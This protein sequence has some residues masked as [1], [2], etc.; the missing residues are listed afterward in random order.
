[1]SVRS[2][3]IFPVWS[4]VGV[5]TRAKLAPAMRFENSVAGRSS[6]IHEIVLDDESYR[7]LCPCVTL[8]RFEKLTFGPSVA[9][10]LTDERRFI[11]SRMFQN[12]QYVVSFP[13]FGGSGPR[14]S[15]SPDG[16]K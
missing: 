13:T 11:V 1:M 7:M 3:A 4:T 5:N 9:V 6:I 2:I 15:W 8:W 12:A 10:T 14:P 16:V